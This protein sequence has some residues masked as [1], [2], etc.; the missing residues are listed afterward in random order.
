M[1]LR[2]KSGTTAVGLRIAYRSELATLLALSLRAATSHPGETAG[3]RSA[4]MEPRDRQGA[5]MA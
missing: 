3:L 2:H 1:K 4:R 5:P